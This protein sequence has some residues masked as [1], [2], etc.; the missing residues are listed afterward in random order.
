MTRYFD[1]TMQP[2][3][4]GWMDGW[5]K[6]CNFSFFAKGD[7][8]ITKNCR[9]II[10]TFIVSIMLSFS[11]IFNQLLRKFFGKNQNGFQRNQSQHYKSIDS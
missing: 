7:I 2:E 1:F 9:G 10:Y 6:G 11:I 8:G 5:I 4:D 3:Y